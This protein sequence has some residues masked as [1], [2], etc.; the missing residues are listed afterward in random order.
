MSEKK[1]TNIE[2]QKTTQQSKHEPRQ[3]S[4]GVELTN[5]SEI[6]KWSKDACFFLYAAFEGILSYSLF[7]LSHPLYRQHITIST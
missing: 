3:K 1:T 5:K 6:K 2:R 7:S 4:F